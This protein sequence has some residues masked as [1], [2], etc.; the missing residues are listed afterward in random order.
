VGH[1]HTMAVTTFAGRPLLIGG[2][3]VSTVTAAAEAPPVLWYAAPPS[4]ALHLVEDGRVTTHWR[5]LPG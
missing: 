1:A 2:G 3:V 5:A 4:F